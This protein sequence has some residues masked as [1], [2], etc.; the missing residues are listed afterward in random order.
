MT[1]TLPGTATPADAVMSSNLP[2][3]GVS[4]E[5]VAADLIDE[6]DV[7]QPVSVDVR[8]RQA[9]AVIVVRRLV[10]DGGVVDDPVP[11]RDT[12][13]GPPVLEPEV[14]E[15]GEARGGLD[16]LLAAL[17]EPRRVLQPVG[18]DKDRLRLLGLRGR[19]GG[20]LRAQRIV[21]CRREHARAC[22]DGC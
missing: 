12:A 18:H 7:R 3:A 9:V 14:V 8:D 10:R 22:G 13:L 4:P 19:C 11:E 17:L 15:R 21:N 2:A 6:V 20:R 1:P 5:L 16:L